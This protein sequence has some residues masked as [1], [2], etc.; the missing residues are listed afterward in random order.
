M[1]SSNQL[2]SFIDT[3]NG[4]IYNGNDQKETLFFN[5]YNNFKIYRAYPSSRRENVLQFIIIDTKDSS[6]IEALFDEFP[7]K[8]I[9]YED[10]TDNWKPELLYD[11]TSRNNQNVYYTDNQIL[12]NNYPNIS[13]YYPNDYV[14]VDVRSPTDYSTYDLNDR[15]YVNAPIAWGITSGGS[16]KIN[17]GV[18]DSKVMVDDDELS[19]KISFPPSGDP[20]ANLNYNPC[21]IVS[22]H[23][24]ASS[25]TIAAKGD[26]NHGV[27]GICYNCEITA[28]DYADNNA[29][30]ELAKTGVKVINMSWSYNR[31]QDPN[32]FI[33]TT[34]GEAL[35]NVIQEIYE[36]YG[37]ILVASA[38]NS[39]S[40]DNSI[41]IDNAPLIVRYGYPASLENVISVSSI[42]H[43][44]DIY[45]N[46][47]NPWTTC[48]QNQQVLFHNEDAIGGT[49][50]VDISPPVA[51]TYGCANGSNQPPTQRE[52]HVFND[53][54]D[55][56]APGWQT[57]SY[58]KLEYGFCQT[59]PVSTSKYTGGT[60]HSAPMVS[61]TIGLMLSKDDCLTANEVEDILKLSSKPVEHFSY[62]S[63]FIGLS[64]SGALQTG[65]AVAFVDEMNKPD[66]TVIIKNQSF[67][68]FDFS[69]QRINNNLIIENVKFIGKNVTKFKAGNEIN[70][71]E[72][73]IL[74]PDNQ[75]S[76]LL[77]IGQV[78]NN[79]CN[80]TQ[81]FS[82]TK[83]DKR[84]R[85]ELGDSKI[86]IEVFPTL[87]SSMLTIRNNSSETELFSIKI[88]DIYGVEVF[89]T[90]NISNE[91]KIDAQ[92][93]NTGIYIIRVY[94]KDGSLIHNEKIIKK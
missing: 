26:N 68:R 76:I 20:Y 7:E 25:I 55:I 92:R 73:T 37:V 77:E 71:V 63:P 13:P 44:Y 74:E 87:V 8:Y 19:G 31:A 60:S 36:D 4:M 86:M 18:S 23:G 82:N 70:L 6:F 5:Q 15:K 58:N 10:I 78:N 64:G 46:P 3:P 59:P 67:N 75:G 42:H 91:K 80:N 9:S 14:T 93:L 40:F 52:G 69:A 27:V 39:M 2:P 56:L 12:A 16:P 84:N 72:G 41:S 45:N 32:T 24:T 1:T 85:Q 50:R 30:I 17:I 90:N 11:N 66:G 22:F 79:S 88:F 57:L 94:D 54:V 61:G 29:L 48:Y 34:F 43:W 47:N 35:N 83:N 21:N 65:N 81:R 28:A 38:G 51:L 89:Q 33:Q 53:K 49:V 62:N